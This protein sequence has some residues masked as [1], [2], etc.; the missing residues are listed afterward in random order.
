MASSPGSFKRLG[1][2]RVPATHGLSHH[3]P[4]PPPK[5]NGLDFEAEENKE[6]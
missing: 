6:N 3:C 5:K 2:L 1:E 4:P